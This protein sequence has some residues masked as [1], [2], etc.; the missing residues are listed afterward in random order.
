MAAQ[1][2]RILPLLVITLCCIGVVEGGYSLLEYFLF[3][4][5]AQEEAA[6][7]GGQE[8][9]EKTAQVPSGKDRDYNII[10]T[11]NLFG[12]PARTEKTA[13][14]PAVDVAGLEKS[15][16]DIVLVGTI[17]GSEGNR[18]VILDKKTKRQELYKEGDEVKGANANVKEIL[19]GKVVLDVQGREELLDLSEA[20]TVRPAGQ[21]PRE[22]AGQQP[23]AGEEPR[24]VQPQPQESATAEE[25]QPPA[26]TAPEA[27]APPEETAPQEVL[28]E[29]AP[30]PEEPR[31]PESKVIR[32]RVIRPN[33]SS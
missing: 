11:R 3:R 27:A 1:I 23:Q 15:D 2:S 22:S 26:E 33:Q 10:L 14:T 17:G 25:A 13:P 24:S 6:Q 8:A 12:Q 30:P 18:A 7:P 5:P 29:A 31:A 20:A 32:P 16:L 4:E 21:A 28:P 9:Q 19:R